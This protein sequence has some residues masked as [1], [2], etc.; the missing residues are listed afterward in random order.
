M[1]AMEFNWGSKKKLK[2]SKMKL[3]MI[4]GIHKKKKEIKKYIYIYLVKI[5]QRGMDGWMGEESH[6]RCC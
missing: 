6:R 5:N 3:T 1:I 4:S 2:G